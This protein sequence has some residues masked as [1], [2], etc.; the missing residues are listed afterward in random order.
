MPRAFSDSEK[1]KIRQRLVDQGY[2]QFSAHGLKKTNIDELASAAGI[3]KGAFYIFY[4]SKE[5]LFMDVAEMAEERFR[6]DVLAVLDQPAVS[7]RANL[8]AV[9]K[10]AFS[11]W[12][13]LPILQQFSAVDVEVLLLRIPEEKLHA[14][15]QA[16]GAFMQE[17]ISRCRQAGIPV[18]RSAGELGGLVY[19]LLLIS[20]NE[21]GLGPIKVE[22]S[23]DVL[24][25][26][27]AAYCL[28]EINLQA[29]GPEAHWPGFDAEV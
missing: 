19:S 26:L 6:R 11:L 23:L 28:G 18:C 8:F 20:L 4:D 16:D 1:I 9:L 21:S 25:E 22:D 12:K 24:L 7:A 14:H 15:M 5:A 10:K 29:P 17:L 2:K 3:S 27:V 13:T